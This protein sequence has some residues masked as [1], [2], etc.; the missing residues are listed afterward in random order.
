VQP[1]G[2]VVNASTADGN[3]SAAWT[4]L[5]GITFPTY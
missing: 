1:N 3:I 5:A 4:S 2:N